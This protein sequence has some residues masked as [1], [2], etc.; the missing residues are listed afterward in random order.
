MEVPSN[1]STKTLTKYVYCGS[2]LS[3]FSRTAL[4]GMIKSHGDVMATES[5][6]G[7]SK[8]VDCFPPPSVR[9]ML[10]HVCAPSVRVYGS[11]NQAQHHSL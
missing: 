9:G 6:A 3:A 5:V 4:P 2:F 11:S 8:Q 1:G 10:W 7:T